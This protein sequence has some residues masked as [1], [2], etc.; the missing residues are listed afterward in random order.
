ML[1]L[2]TLRCA[3]VLFEQGCMDDCWAAGVAGLPDVGEP[4]SARLS[5]ARAASR[6]DATAHAARRGMEWGQVRVS[7]HA[8]KCS[9]GSEATGAE[10]EPPHAKG[11]DFDDSDEGYKCRIPPT[12]CSHLK[13]IQSPHRSLPDT[14]MLRR[15]PLIF[16]FT[17]TA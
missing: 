3:P 16:C 5:D 14:I 2:Q 4:R 8:C 13:T 11:I 1:L 15:I 6:W 7:L 9:G 12:W 10:P 17:V